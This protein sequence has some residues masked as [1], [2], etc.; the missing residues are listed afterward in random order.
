MKDTSARG[1]RQA[2]RCDRSSKRIL[3][4]PQV[5]E[6][7]KVEGVRSG[8]GPR[9]SSLW[10]RLTDDPGLAPELCGKLPQA[11]WL[12]HHDPVGEIQR[13]PRAPE[14]RQ[15][16]IQICSRQRD[17]NRYTLPS[18]PLH[19]RGTLRGMQRNQDIQPFLPK[20][21]E[22]TN[23][24]TQGNQ[25][26]PPTF[27]GNGISRNHARTRGADDDDSRHGA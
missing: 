17:H 7:D 8:T 14:P 10:H 1:F 23:L 24:M 13:F 19:R 22:H 15:I 26:L 21:A 16:L 9:T 12:Q 3:H 6:N 11:E 2:P 27:R 4:P 18:R 5:R 20:F 25:D